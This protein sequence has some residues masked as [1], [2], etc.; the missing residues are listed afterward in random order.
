MRIAF[1]VAQIVNGHNLNI[2][3]FVAF[4][5]GAQNVAANAAIAVD[6]DANCHGELS[7]V[8]EEVAQAF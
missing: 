8:E 7:R 6:S 5:V 2:V 1:G 4:I 3:L